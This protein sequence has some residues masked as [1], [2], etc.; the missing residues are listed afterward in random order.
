MVENC[1]H[2]PVRDGLVDLTTYPARATGVW[3]GY[4]GRRRPVR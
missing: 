1:A 2:G 3:E 4:G